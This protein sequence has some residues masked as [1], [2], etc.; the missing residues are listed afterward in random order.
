[1]E[2]KLYDIE[3]KE[4]G[5]VSIPDN[6][7]ADKIDRYFLHEIVKYYLAGK[8]VGTA[9]TKTRA[10]V[11]GGGK[12]PWRQKHTGRA[13]QG[14]I[15]SPLWKGGGVVFGPKP[16]DFSI[17]IPK[18]KLDIA[19]KQV[20]KNRIEENKFYVFENLSFQSPKTKNFEKIVET[21][22]IKGEKILIVMDE[23]N[24]NAIKSIR[25]FDRVK[26]V[27]AM[28]LNAY[29]LITSDVVIITQKA[30]DIIKARMEE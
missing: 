17:D 5:S 21:L 15:R 23:W 20:L 3:G 26:Y 6:V 14:S 22:N 1:M 28:D 19:I 2:T 11:S 30:I 18:K 16:R 12:K 24:E 8:R 29:D 27:R 7:L 10:E 13:R 9:S 4:K 25:N